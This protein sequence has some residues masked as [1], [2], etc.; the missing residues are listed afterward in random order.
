MMVSCF[1]STCLSFLSSV[2]WVCLFYCLSVL[3]SSYQY[4]WSL[5]C[6]FVNVILEISGNL[7]YEFLAESLVFASWTGN[8]RSP[9]EIL[10]CLK[11]IIND[12]SSR[13]EHSIGALTS[14]NRDVWAKAREKLAAAGNSI[15]TFIVIVAGIWQLYLLLLHVVCYYR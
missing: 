3:F 8:V 6:K 9:V 11:Y 10:S 4:S 14:E 13:P 5:H 2:F 15:I 1:I 12:K 7:F